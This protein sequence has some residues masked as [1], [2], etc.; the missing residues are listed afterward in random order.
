MCY[1][2]RHLCTSRTCEHDYVVESD[3]CYYSQEQVQLYG[4][5]YGFEL[6]QKQCGDPGLSQVCSNIPDRRR[7]LLRCPRC[8]HLAGR[9]DR[10]CSIENLPWCETFKAVLKGRCV[11]RLRY[12][13]NGQPLMLETG[14][15]GTLRY[16]GG[17]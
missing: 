17:V 15:L 8:R 7:G 16:P 9:C 4:C 14:W 2:N 5:P 13:V 3:F 1:T 11:S 6:R 10:N 12:Q